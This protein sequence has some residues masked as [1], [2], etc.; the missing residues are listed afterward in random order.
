VLRII[1]LQDGTI[2]L[3][4]AQRTVCVPPRGALR[5]D[6]MELLPSFF[7]ISYAYRFGPCAHD[8]T[9]ATLSDAEHGRVIS[10][11]CHFPVA[12]VLPSRDL[13]LEVAVEQLDGRW[14][15]RE[16]WFHLLP[17]REH[18]IA[19]QADHD[20]ATVPDGELRALNLVRPARYS[21]RT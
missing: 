10:E 11:A 18:R 16:N 21:G 12:R 14:W 13:G 20:G 19:L 6:S 1:C 9:I 7:D 4:E 5:I 2:P 3:R 8:V 15:L 17:G